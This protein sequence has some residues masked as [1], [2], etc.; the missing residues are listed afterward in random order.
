MNEPPTPVEKA[1]PSVD[2][3]RFDRRSS[4]YPSAHTAFPGALKM[5]DVGKRGSFVGTVSR[6]S[7][8]TKIGIADKGS[9]AGWHRRSFLV[10]ITMTRPTCGAWESP[11]WVCL[12]AAGRE[13]DACRI[14]AWV[15]TWF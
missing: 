2:E 13:T 14:G 9:L 10:N 3:L 7:S 8:R 15:C 5:D 6:G 12:W 11:S 1:R 4:H